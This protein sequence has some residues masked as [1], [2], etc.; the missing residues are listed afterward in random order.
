SSK[1]NSDSSTWQNTTLTGKNISLKAEGDTT[2]RGATATAD[3]IDVKTGGTL[4]IES[5]QDIAE[6]MSKDSQVGGRVQVSVGTAWDASGYASASKANGSYKGVGQQSGLFAGD[7]GYHVDAGHVNLV[8]GAI[9][10][11]NAANS[12]LTAQTLI[13]TDLKN[14]MDYRASS[15]SISGGFGAGGEKPTDADGKPLAT[16]NA[17]GQFKDIGSNVANG[18]YG[19]ADGSNFSGGV[20]MTTSGSDSSTTYATLTEGNITIGG[21]KV[22]AAELGVNTDASKA[23]E[24]ISSL[25]DLQKLMQEQQAMSSAA[26]TVVSTSKQIAGDVAAA[27]TKAATDA[28]LASLGSDKDRADFLAKSSEAQRAILSTREDYKDAQ[29]WTTGGSYSRALDAV[30]TAIVGSVAGQGGGQVAANALAPYAAEFIGSKFDPNHGKDPNATLQLISHALLGALLAEANG[31][32]ASNGAVAAGGGELASQYLTDVLYGGG[33][34]AKLEERQKENILALSQALGA[35]AGGWGGQGLSGAAVGANIAGNSVKNNRMLKSEELARIKEMSNGDAVRE[36]ELT[37]AACA[38]V[39]CSSGFPE[40]SEERAQW[41]A[42]EAIGSAPE[43]LD[44]RAWLKAQVLPGYVYTAGNSMAV[45]NL[46]FNYD[47]TDAFLDWNSRNQIGT[48]AL[49]GLQLLG[50]GLQAAGGVLVSTTCE[51]VIGCVAAA[52]LVGTGYD[53]AIA[54]YST[55]VSGSPTTTWGS[56]LIQAGGVSPQ[57]AELLYGLTQ[58]GA[59]AGA[60]VIKTGAASLDSIIPPSSSGAVDTAQ[61]AK[62]VTDLRSGLTS[63][64]K[65]SGNVAVADVNV[66]GLPTS[67]AAHSSIANP[68]AQQKL[69]GLVGDAGDVF[70]TFSVPNKSGVPV[71]RSGDSEAKILGNLAQQLGENRGAT[72]TISIFTERAACASCMG[73]VEQFMAK[74][75]GIRVSVFDN[76]GVLLRPQSASPKP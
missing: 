11:T 30:T 10:S 44:D 57:V 47:G 32:L 26:G 63:D 9:A 37:A 15:A 33:D 69:G 35:L 3:R 64:L 61:W 34:P 12:E 56:R 67:I 43:A 5:L 20:P 7:G 58:V 40:G 29:K 74:Y 17:A 36:A 21:K 25:P 53:N 2:L 14:E 51:T 39:E 49:G 62:R 16:P 23:H 41:A 71:P 48:R 4:T 55:L 27:K 31:G 38:M 42:I 59:A 70:E 72:G 50:G 18:K 54:G 76:K 73:V 1:S 8:G 22:T 75:P 65:R 45:D 6:S 60:P 19:Q 66:D 68:T 24:A 28:Y 52:Y 46:L 13:F